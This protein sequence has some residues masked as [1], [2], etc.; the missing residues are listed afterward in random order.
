MA[1][2]GAFR[3]SLAT[4]RAESPA[5]RADIALP[6]N[7]E[8]ERKPW[9]P[10]FTA[11]APTR[12]ANRTFS[13]VIGSVPLART[14]RCTAFAA[15]WAAWLK[16]DSIFA[17]SLRLDCAAAATA[18]FAASFARELGR[19]GLDLSDRRAASARFRAWIA[20]FEDAARGTRRAR[21]GVAAPSEAR[22]ARA[23]VR[24][25]A[26]ASCGG[27]GGPPSPSAAA[28]RT[29]RSMAAASLAFAAFA[30]R[31]PADGSCRAATVRA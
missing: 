20:A 15:C 3:I 27:R 7:P 26:V 16:F 5:S 19:V 25:G 2:R 11:S 18:A 22:R 31:L 24:V 28:L 1:V 30:V 13:P 4:A 10:A 6:V 29:T 21:L 9:T 17:S 23:A 8:A 14:P 12:A